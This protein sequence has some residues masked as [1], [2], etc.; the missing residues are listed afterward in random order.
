MVWDYNWNEIIYEL[1]RNSILLVKSS[2]KA[3]MTSSA[4]HD[5]AF[6]NDRGLGS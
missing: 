2:D 6:V 4:A 1:A 5:S 3:G